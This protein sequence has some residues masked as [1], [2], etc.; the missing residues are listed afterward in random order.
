MTSFLQQKNQQ[1]ELI[2]VV[3]DDDDN[4][5]KMNDD[6][7]DLEMIA[8]AFPFQKIVAFLFYFQIEAMK[9]FE[10]IVIQPV[11]LTCHS[12]RIF[13]ILLVDLY[14]YCY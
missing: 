9:G 6:G 14:S 5:G 7:S 13:A 3:G 2:D 1:M 12:N 11:I 4:F 10:D 8:S